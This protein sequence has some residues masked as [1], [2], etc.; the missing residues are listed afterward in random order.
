[1][2]RNCKQCN[3]DEL[4]N[5]SSKNNYKKNC[6]ACSAEIYFTNNEQYIDW[7][8]A[9]LKNQKIKFG[10]IS[11]LVVTGIIIITIGLSWVIES[12]AH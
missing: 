12:V 6:P 11:I 3:I 1:M 8:S 2:V 4:V 5:R 10:V 9:Y 7:L